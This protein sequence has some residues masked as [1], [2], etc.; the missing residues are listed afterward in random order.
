M[1]NPKKEYKTKTNKLNK[2][3]VKIYNIALN[4]LMTLIFIIFIVVIILCNILKTDKTFSEEENRTLATMPNFTIK[5]FLSGDFTEEYT[6]YV[7][8]NF[9]GKKGF[10][11][12]KTNLEKL[13][14]KTEINSIFIGEDGQLFEKFKEG[15]EEETTAKISAI[16]SF[17]ER[18]SNLNISFILTPTATKVLEDNL[19]KYAP[20]DDELSYINNVFSGLNNNINTINPYEALNENK[21]EYIFYKTDHH[22]TSKGAYITYTVFCE[23]LGLTPMNID[24]FKITTVTN[25]FYGSLTS[26]IGIQS[27]KPDS[28]DVYIPKESDF[29][30][31]YVDNQKKSTSLFDSTYLDKKDKYNIFTGGNHSLINIKTLGDPNRKLLV[32]K[33]SYANCFLPFLTSH[34]GEIN[35]VDLRYFYDDLDKLIENKEITDI[36]F[37]YNANT[38]NSN[39]SILNI[40]T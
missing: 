16:N 1:E 38:F 8:D 37:L 21:N 34:Y 22:W 17:S 23:K 2:R 12:I 26:K 25:S 3:K 30:V 7:E 40:G 11:S 15:S 31:N 18:Y 13:S 28:I 9:A 36:L 24:N 4:R 32:I 5:S 27:K 14:G 35:V 10:V 6:K 29:I 20:N 19:P 33:D 39:D